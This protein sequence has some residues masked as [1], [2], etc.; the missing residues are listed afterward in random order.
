MPGRPLAP[1]PPWKGRRVV[2]GVTGGIAAYKA[3]QVARDLTRL[4]AQV[5]VI[6]TSGATEFVRPLSFQGVTGRPVHESLFSVEGAALH[7]RLGA[8]ADL[9]VVAPATADFLARAAHGRADDLLTTTL[10][11]TRAPVL[12]APA[13]ND[14]MW[15]HPQTVANAAH[16]RDTL[17]Y[18]MVGPGVGPLAVGEGEGAGRMVEPDEIVEEAG[19]LLGSGGPLTGKRVLVTAGPTREPLD[20]VRYLGNRSSGRMGFALARE[21]RLRGAEVTLVTGPS[22]L[23]PPVGVEVVR[24]EQGTEMLE[25]VE[26]RIGEADLVV[27]AAAVADFRPGSSATSK[28]KRSEGGVPEVRLVENPDIA[29]LTASLRKEGAV[30]VGFALETDDLLANARKKLETKGFHLIAANPASEEGAGFESETNRVVILD[31]A[32]GEDVLPTLGKDEV[33]RRILDRAEPLLGWTDP[34]ERLRG[35]EL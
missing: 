2:L 13:M 19:R 29:A 30:A 21:A 3:V 34:E 8:E 24:V 4:G 7:I 33:A 26:R 11:A 27:Y 35:P 25:A 28:M 15:A 9:V 17:R 14:R 10:L 18:R 20:P 32:G 22:A 31:A 5:D 1:R 16:C 6:L 23:L 12:L